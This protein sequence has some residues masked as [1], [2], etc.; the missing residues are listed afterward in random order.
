MTLN[1]KNQIIAMLTQSMLGTISDNFRL[2][3][4]DLEQPVLKIHFILSEDLGVDRE[5]IEDIMSNFEVCMMDVDINCAG[6]ASQISIIP[7]TLPLP[8]IECTRVFQRRDSIECK[9][10]GDLGSD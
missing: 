9:S 2:I 1:E 6:F 4:V 8:E 10:E 3:A 5:E 7:N